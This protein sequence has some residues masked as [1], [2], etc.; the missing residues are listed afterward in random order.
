MARTASG[1]MEKI[2]DRV[3]PMPSHPNLLAA[4]PFAST[5]SRFTA[6]SSSIALG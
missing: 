5:S 3:K 4:I 6:A 2:V 1:R